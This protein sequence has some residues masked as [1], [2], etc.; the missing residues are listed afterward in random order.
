MICDIYGA[1]ILR[2]HNCEDEPEQ[3]KDLRKT[4]TKEE[5]KKLIKDVIEEY[6]KPESSEKINYLANE[7]HKKEDMYTADDARNDMIKTYF[8][9][10]KPSQEDNKKFMSGF[11]NGN[12]ISQENKDKFRNDYPDVNLDD[13]CSRIQT[14]R[15]NGNGNLK[16]IDDINEMSF[17][18]VSSDEGTSWQNNRGPVKAM[19]EIMLKCD[20][21][22]GVPA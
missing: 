11:E 2:I 21:N 15:H 1:S 4:L 9:E 16:P 3:S 13:L 18:F 8:P 17:G 19:L 6:G 7:A 20:N 10:K 14:Y 22:G 12:G 5:K